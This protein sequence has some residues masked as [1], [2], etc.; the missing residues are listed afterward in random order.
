[1]SRY[2]DK[3]YRYIS[4][5]VKKRKY[6]KALSEVLKYMEE[7]PYDKKGKYL[8]AYIIEGM[9]NAKK[10]AKI[11]KE[12]IDSNADAKYNC[13]FRL[14]M[15]DLDSKKE[16]AAVKKFY[17]IIDESPYNEAASY[18]ALVQIEIEHN[19]IKKAIE[20]V[21]KFEGKDDR[22]VLSK[23]Q[24]YLLS[25]KYDL[26][27]E[28]LKEIGNRTE[29]DIS[30]KVDI[31]KGKIA[32]K[33]GD[34]YKAKEYFEHALIGTQNARY[35]DIKLEI[36]RLERKFQKFDEALEICDFVIKNDPKRVSKTALLEGDIYLGKHEYDKSEE[37][38]KI[39]LGKYKD[40]FSKINLK[41]GFLMFVQN[42]YEEAVNYLLKVGK[43]SK[44]Y[45][46][47]IFYL[48]VSYIRL[49]E[50]KKAE[51]YVDSI[52]DNS[53]LKLLIDRN[54]GRNVEPNG[55]IEKQL[56]HYSVDEAIKHS[57]RIHTNDEVECMFKENISVDKLFY[58]IQDKLED[59][60]LIGCDLFNHYLIPYENCG[61][62]GSNT[63]NAIVVV[64][65]PITKHIMTMY[66]VYNVKLAEDNYQR[67]SRIDKFYKKYGL[68]K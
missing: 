39:V 27:L 36:A 14:A 48:T 23:A 17:K 40:K 54:L 57:D 6:N 9:G 62:S 68:K 47:A 45:G 3:K 32:S 66:P 26:A 22:I 43:K 46:S 5:L 30:R 16:E 65:E 41:L 42:R 20:I 28:T 58:E 44:E 61:Y 2:D 21:N 37:L 31:I 7:F 51:K 25:E 63:A 52:H 34:Y 1:M 50:Y 60:N 33:K 59:S 8:Y 55:Y 24:L 56:L 18:M 53:R 15:I 29:L 4:N 11:Y 13:L 35:F 10:A 38:Y 64:V 67:E 12:L 19:N 49:K